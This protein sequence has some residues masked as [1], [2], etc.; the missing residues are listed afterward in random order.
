MKF[1][2]FHHGIQ[3]LLGQSAGHSHAKSSIIDLHIG[4]VN[5]L[6]AQLAVRIILLSLA[7]DEST[8]DCYFQYDKLLSFAY[9]AGFRQPLFYL[10][11]FPLIGYFPYIIKL[12]SSP[13]KCRLWLFLDRL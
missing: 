6:H 8:T 3:Q 2:A 7:I 1:F 9:K 12:I 4:L 13:N 11:F 5:F 10:T